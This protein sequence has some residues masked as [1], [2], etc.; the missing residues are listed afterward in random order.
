MAKKLN[1]KIP[2]L[3]KVKAFLQKAVGLV[4]WGLFGLLVI[5]E[6]VIAKNSVGVIFSSPPPSDSA[7]SSAAASTKDSHINFEAYSKAVERIQASDSYLPSTAPV[8]DPFQ[9]AGQ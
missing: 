1:I 6:L 4:L 9:P 5:W 3:D 7:S 8:N 2:S